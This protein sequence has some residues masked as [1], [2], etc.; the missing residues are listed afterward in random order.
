MI[1]ESTDSY[2]ISVS[3]LIISMIIGLVIYMPGFWSHRRYLSAF[4][5]TI[6]GISTGVAIVSRFNPGIILLIILLQAYRVFSLLR[7][8]RE[9]I[10]VSALRF[11]V[12][13]SEIWLCITLSLLI[14]I[15]LVAGS[16]LYLSVWAN[17]MVVLELVFSAIFLLHIR[18]SLKSTKIDLPPKFIADKDLPSITIAV[19]ARNETTDLTDCLQ[20]ILANN[21]PKMEVLVLDDCSQDSTSDIIRSFAHRGVRFISGKIPPENWLAKNWA[22]K[23][24]AD[25]ADGKYIIFCGV[26]VRFET[27]SIR[28]IIELAIQNE[29][30]MMSVLPIR[31]QTSS[32]SEVIQPMRYWRE[33]AIPKMPGN[34]PPALSTVWVANKKFL[35]KNGGFEAYKQS[36]RP[37][38]H[39]AKRANTHGVYRFYS[40]ISGLGI[41]SVKSYKAQLN[42]ALRT[43]YPEHH[44]RPEEIFYISVWFMVVFIMPMPIFVLSIYMGWGFVAFVA[45][46]SV[47]ILLYTHF[48]VEQL[49]GTQ[50]IYKKMIMFPLTV[51]A[52]ISLINYSMWAYE[53]SEIIWKGRNICLPVLRAI[54][55]LPRV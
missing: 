9:L 29:L 54:P 13:R 33:L 51:F 34:F 21:Y 19:P 45:L 5:I 43:R 52:E 24:L 2:L 46:L 16:Y 7:I 40:S 32:F 30:S 20:S 11:R 41:F 50:K 18:N 15:Q 25:E 4:V 44:K 3:L 42:T 37:E 14:F 38:K 35:S 49:T 36:V 27:D 48:L 53:F 31:N 47:I 1:I 17:L 8:E 12:R 26:D 10:N 28:K 23:Q 55:R 6:I 22:Y 39:F